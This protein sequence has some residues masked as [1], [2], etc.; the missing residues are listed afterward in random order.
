MPFLPIPEDALIISLSSLRF[1]SYINRGYD[2]QY[3]K[4][5]GFVI[6]QQHPHINW[7]Y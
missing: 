3:F 5:E 2:F 6:E 7:E 4:N 1:P